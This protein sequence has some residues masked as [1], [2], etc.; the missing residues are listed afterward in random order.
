MK[1]I[2]I[3]GG[4]GFIGSHLALRLVEQ[5]FK[6]RILDTLSEQIHGKDPEVTSPLYKSI[7]NKTEFIQGSVTSVEDWENAIK[8]QDAIVHLAAETGTGQS[9]YQVEKYTSVNIQ[10][11]SLL[12]DILTNKPHQVKK[13]VIASSR[14]FNASLPI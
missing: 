7:I 13:V 5:G 1:K 10:G 11:T 2:L 6:I 9:M 8:D 12:L 3:T 14:S 4:A